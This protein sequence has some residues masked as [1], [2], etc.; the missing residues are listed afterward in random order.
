MSPTPVSVIVRARDERRSLERC[1][2]L[3]DQQ[4][5]VGEGAELIV[6]DGGSS[7]GTVAVARRHGATVLRVDR[8]PYSF[9]DALNR[10]AAAASGDVLVA[11]S[12]HAFP[13]DP[14]WLT[15]LAAA[16]TDDRVACACG[17]RYGPDGEWLLGPLYQ[18]EAGA[19]RRP[20]WG[21][22]NAAG[23]FR[24]SLWRQR[25]FRVELP[26]CEDKEWALHWLSQGYRCVI[27]ASLLVDHDHTHDPLR[28]VYRR[29]QREARAYAMFL[30]S[31]DEGGNGA[32]GLLRQWWSDL[33]WYNS[34]LRA[35]LSPRRMARLLGGHAGWAQ[36]RG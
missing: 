4:R 30:P 15:R 6:V 26:A 32:H 18:D 7:D 13:R 20:E 29:A 23:A 19:R 12:A 11:L 25:P 31:R 33:R 8:H 3:I 9:A 16:F 36:S 24:A 34:P 5:G 27:D 10:G 1:L 28:S 22:A 14:G 2:T 17:D 21:Y 35:R